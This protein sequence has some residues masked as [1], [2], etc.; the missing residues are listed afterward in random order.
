MRAL[1]AGTGSIGRKHIAVLRKLLPE[2]EFI[3]LRRESYEDHLSRSL[4]A[5]IAS[6][7]HDAIELQPDFALI[8]T[9]T[10]LHLELLEPL[11]LARIPVYIEKPVVSSFDDAS[12]LQSVIEQLSSDMPVT[13]S[14]FMLRHLG[15]IKK[16]CRLISNGE[17]G[18]IVRA[19]LEVG[20][21]L[22]D[23][24][25]VRDYRNSY[26][27]NSELGG[28]VIL[29]LSHEL[30]IARYLFGEFDIVKGI[31]GHFSDLEIDSEDT[32]SIL[33]GNYDG[34]VVCVNMDYLC[35]KLRRNY[36]IVG[37]KATLIWDLVR[38]TVSIDSEKGSIVVTCTDSDFDFTESFIASWR[39]FLYAI[40]TGGVT[41]QGVEDA[42]V[43]TI[44]ALRARESALV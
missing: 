1:V 36:T 25:P 33:L 21:W 14:G 29:D 17:I 35:R 34:P 20:Q 31:A 3:F 28:G 11:L 10:S 18:R 5:T 4:C 8:A 37:D 39:E 43:S 22:P 9:P 12:R 44:L 24:R 16:I 7:T 19:T 23:W 15:S 42:L 41:Q 2:L 30:D 38:K 27:A 13:Q 6:S 26:S 32:A 40:E